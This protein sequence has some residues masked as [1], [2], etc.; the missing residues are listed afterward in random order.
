MTTFRTRDRT[1]A[2]R[3]KRALVDGIKI[4]VNYETTNGWSRLTGMVRSVHRINPRPLK[5]CWEITIVECREI[6]LEREGAA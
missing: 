6:E 4:T 5:V 3:C 1:L 2:L